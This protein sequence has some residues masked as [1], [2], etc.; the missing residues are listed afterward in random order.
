M[1]I[2]RTTIEVRDATNDSD[3]TS[4]PTSDGVWDESHLYSP[5]SET[6]AILC[7][8]SQQQ[9]KRK[10]KNGKQKT[11]NRKQK[12]ENRKQKTENGKQNTSTTNKISKFW[13]KERAIVTGI[14][15]ERSTENSAFRF[16]VLNTPP[17]FKLYGTYVHTE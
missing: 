5:H 12:T 1:R 15:K 6:T 17:L 10:T 14:H 7:G 2:Q 3:S 8:N 4:S 13:T 16:E 11:E 9:K